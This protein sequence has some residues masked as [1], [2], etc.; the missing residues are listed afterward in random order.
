MSY[1]STLLA[2]PHASPPPPAPDETPQPIAHW[3]HT[4]GLF[5]LFILT[6]TFTEHRAASHELGNTA[7]IP[8]YLA[9]IAMEW[10]DRKS[11]V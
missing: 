6:T 4:V 11:V 5:G 3:T 7:H 10:T 1:D 9:S 8:S 2:E